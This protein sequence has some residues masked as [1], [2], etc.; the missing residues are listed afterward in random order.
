MV[1]FGR[2]IRTQAIKCLYGIVADK[3]FYTFVCEV[4]E[5]P[6]S[7]MLISFLQ[8]FFFPLETAVPKLQ[9]CCKWS[10]YARSR[11][12]TSKQGAAPAQTWKLQQGKP[13]SGVLTISVTLL[14]DW[15][16]CFQPEAGECFK[17]VF[18]SRCCVWPCSTPSEFP[19]IWIMGGDARM[20][21]HLGTA[22]PDPAVPSL[23]GPELLT[24]NHGMYLC[25]S[26]FMLLGY[27]WINM[28]W[29]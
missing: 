19:C 20:G 29:C 2:S 21:A 16:K 4:Q 12:H 22:K 18:L 17:D 7:T 24:L 8:L 14:G 1:N 3:S 6:S 28:T 26:S 11:P 10:H 23:L 25:R 13:P 9:C 27:Y 15:W 5:F